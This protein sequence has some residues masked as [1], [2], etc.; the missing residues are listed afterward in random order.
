[1]L[2]A[3]DLFPHAGQVEPTRVHEARRALKAARALMRLFTPL[4]GG[5]AYE[6]LSALDAARRKLGRARDFDVMP[7]VLASLAG[8]IDAATSEQLSGAI[9]LE[10][11]VA[12]IA[13]D[14]IDVVALTTQLRAL[15][16]GAEGWSLTDVASAHLLGAVRA[17]YR[18]ARRSGRAALASLDAR[19]L[20]ELRV[21]TVDL[22]H[23]LALFAPAWPAQFAALAEEIQRLRQNL[24]DHNDLATLAEFAVSRRDLSLIQLS[25]LA[26]K[27]ERRQRRLT[28]KAGAHFARIFAERPGAFE[29]RILAYLAHPKVKPAGESQG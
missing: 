18:A 27:V 10:R 4:I 8:E 24:G 12:R 20:H 14:E 2:A 3:A 22:G 5:P 15:A 17:H 1:M 29:R 11:E 19:D 7:G 26:L 23:Q 6:A 13:H 25:D 9:A 28:R 21:H 16:R